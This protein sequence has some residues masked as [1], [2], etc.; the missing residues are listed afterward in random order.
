MAAKQGSLMIL[1]GK[2]HRKDNPLMSV[3]LQYYVI[4][5][6]LRSPHG[7]GA[8]YRAKPSKCEV[9]VQ[10]KGETKAILSCLGSTSRDNEGAKEFPAGRLRWAQHIS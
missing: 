7:C 5:H 6:S 9:A 8:A 3:V 10:Q 2:L 4:T 1:S